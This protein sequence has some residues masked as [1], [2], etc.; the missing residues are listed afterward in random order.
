MCMCLSHSSLNKEDICSKSSLKLALEAS[1]Q[2]IVVLKN[3][4]NTLPLDINEINSEKKKIGLIGPTSDVEKV[5]KGNYHG[6]APF[7]YTA[8][9]GMRAYI[10]SEDQL[11]QSDGCRIADDNPDM[12]PEAVAIAKQSDIIV[13]VG[14]SDQVW[15]FCLFCL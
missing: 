6:I 8:L 15:F 10:G 7:V 2:S 14:G 1:R 4:D 13:Y 12:I 5:M 9:D 3:K 11:M